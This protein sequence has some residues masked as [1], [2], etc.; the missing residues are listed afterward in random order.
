MILAVARDAGRVLPG[1]AVRALP[2]SDLHPEH[3]HKT[4][5]PERDAAAELAWAKETMDATQ[6]P[7]ALIAP[8]GVLE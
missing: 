7:V 5:S 1:V 4:L 2:R 3:W 8:A 6:K